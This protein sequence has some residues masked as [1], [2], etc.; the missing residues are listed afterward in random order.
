MN[1]HLNADFINRI[2]SIHSEKDF[3]K[4]VFEVFE[5]QIKN[6]PIYSEYCNG[7][8]KNK[9]LNNLKEIPFLP[10][11]LFKQ[12]SII[13]K[14]LNS[15]KIFISS[16]T[17]KKRSKHM[18][19]DLSI[20]E[21]SFENSFVNFYGA[22]NEYCILAL[23]PNYL[24]QKNSSLIYMM[25]N[26][27][28]KSDFSESGFFLNKLDSLAK[29]LQDLEK[30]SI[31]T[32]LFGTSY[33]LLDFAKYYPMQLNYTTIIETGGMKG[34]RKEMVK[35]EMYSILKKAFQLKHIHSEYGMT[36]L[37]S[38][39]YSKKDGR[40]E[41]PKWMRVLIRDVSD[42]L[43]IVEN[44]NSGGIN[45]IDLANIYSCPFI[46]TEDLG[47]V[48]SKNSFTILGRLNH[49]DIRGCNLLVT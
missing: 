15:E 7:I 25:Q 28:K 8:L 27:I 26:L 3:Q 2:F 34:R 20:Y 42:P 49:S 17:G 5:I 48:F 16:G 21:R 31:K 4:L 39:A 43:S 12:K 40:F 13:H 38:Q 11:E 44:G 23:L 6:N 33:S 45:V 37:L 9:Q 30:K 29:T 1:L 32:L 35:E 14:N 19:A 46:A 47:K 24:E 36:E 18:I 10:I 41:T 22:A